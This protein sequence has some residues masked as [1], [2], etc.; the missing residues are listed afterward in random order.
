VVG[1]AFY[2]FV[3]IGFAHVSNLILWCRLLGFTAWSNLRVKM[4]GKGFDAFS[5]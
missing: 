5:R 3:F 1:H 4:V 2:L